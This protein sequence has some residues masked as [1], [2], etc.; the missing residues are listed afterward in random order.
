VIERRDVTG[1]LPRVPRDAADIRRRGEELLDEVAARSRADARARLM[2]LRTAAP[3]IGQAAVAA[4][5]A[6]W[7]ANRIGAG[8]GPPF[9]A[10]VAA[11]VS[12]GT[13]LGQRLRRTV[14]LVIGVSLGVGMG[15]LLIRAI[16]NG[17]GQL[18]LVVVLAMA[19][20]VVLDGGQLM[21]MQAATSSV[22]V[23][24]LVP[25]NQ[26][27]AGLDRCANAMIGGVVGIAVGLL[28]LPLNPLTLA[29]RTTLP[30]TTGIADGLQAVADALRKADYEA[31]RGA[32]GALRG[33]NAK[34]TAMTNAVVTSEEIARVAPVRWRSRDRFGSYAA[35]APQLDYAHRDARVLARRATVLL[36][37]GHACPADLIEAIAGLARASRCLGEELANGADPGVSRRLLLDAYA[38]GRGSLAPDSPQTVVVVIAELRALTYDLL[39][40]TGLNR[41]DALALLDA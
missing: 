29:R 3:L 11:V 7:L 17:T 36:R 5:L 14:E 8:S 41:V 28:L 27:L 16:G 39:R 2:R 21:V 18:M 12:I 13:A 25:T 23:A 40:A 26:G 31:G 34:V 37:A 20:A 10:P 38:A 35:A 33:M 24:V 1:P 22:L 32:L 15:D 4:G 9:F 19:A 30:V 6:W